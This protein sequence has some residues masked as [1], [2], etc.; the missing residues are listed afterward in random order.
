MTKNDPTCSSTTTR[1][2]PTPSLTSSPA[3]YPN[4]PTLPERPPCQ[5]SLPTTVHIRRTTTGSS[6]AK[7]KATA[8]CQLH[9]RMEGRSTKRPSTFSTLPCAAVEAQTVKN[10]PSVSTGASGSPLPMLVA[11]RGSFMRVRPSA[12]A[13]TGRCNPTT[14]RTCPTSAPLCARPV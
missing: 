3:W 14:S 1:P 10:K 8:S 2:T 12:R 9:R 13:R 11:L 4:P 5:E 7:L 6:S